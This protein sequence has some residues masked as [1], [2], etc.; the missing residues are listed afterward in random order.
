M[1]FILYL[2][3]YGAILSSLIFVGCLEYW[4]HDEPNYEEGEIYVLFKQNVTKD[5]AIEIVR[6]YNCTIIEFYHG[7]EIYKGS[8]SDLQAAV[9]VP[10]GLE[11]RYVNTFKNDTN[12]LYA[13]LCTIDR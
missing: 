8:T 12:V 6:D 9:K 10:V 3:L 4:N 7:P 1:G 2:A 5:T 11:K 13:E